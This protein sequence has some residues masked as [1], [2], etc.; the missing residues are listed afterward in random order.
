[1]RSLKYILPATFLLAI[2]SQ[3]QQVT[4][5]KD[6]APIMINKCINCHRPESSAPMSLMSYEE[7][8]PWAKSI[9]EQVVK[10]NMPPW[11]ADPEHGS[12]SNDPS[13]TQE[14]H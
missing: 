5:T 7:A 14:E 13:L 6:I 8:R 12:W 2:A 3:A 4:Y 1:M 10:R 9:R 11:F